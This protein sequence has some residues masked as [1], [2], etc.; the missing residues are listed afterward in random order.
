VRTLFAI[1]RDL[2]A[3][4]FPSGISGYNNDASSPFWQ[5]STP[6]RLESANF[7]ADFR[8]DSRNSSRTAT[9]AGTVRHRAFPAAPAASIGAPAWPYGLAG[10]SGHEEERNGRE[11]RRQ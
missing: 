8:P 10:T 3:G 6:F 1:T 2:I 4:E 11:D 5:E 7:R 9:T